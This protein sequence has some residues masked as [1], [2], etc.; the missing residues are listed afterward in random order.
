M[1]RNNYATYGNGELNLGEEKVSC[2]IS[3][4]AAG[5]DMSSL[6]LAVY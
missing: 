5:T 1:S 2:V 4:L 3:A 6:D